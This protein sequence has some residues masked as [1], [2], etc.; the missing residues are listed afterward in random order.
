MIR[1][2]EVDDKILY[3]SNKKPDLRLLHEVLRITAP[4]KDIVSCRH[5]GAPVIEL[6]YRKRYVGWIALH[7]GVTIRTSFW[8]TD[9]EILDKERFLKW[10]DRRGMAGPRRRAEAEIGF[11][12]APRKK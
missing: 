6:Y 3:E 7:D 11:K 9:A 12:K 2:S 5:I 4:G 1:K 10:F 8:N